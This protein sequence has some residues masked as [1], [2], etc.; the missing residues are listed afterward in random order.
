MPR[1][2]VY[3]LAHS[4]RREYESG[5]FDEG[6]IDSPPVKTKHWGLLLLM[7]LVPYRYRSCTTPPASPVVG[8]H[9]TSF[10]K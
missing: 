6:S 2:R 9:A 3:F 8:P 1:H 5:S 4:K 10:S 7:G